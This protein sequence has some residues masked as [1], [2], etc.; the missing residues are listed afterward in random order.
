MGE[1]EY[2]LR[3]GTRE[4]FKEMNEFHSL[5]WLV[6]KYVNMHR[7]VLAI[8][9]QFSIQKVYLTFFKGEGGSEVR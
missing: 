3:R 4:R 8:F 2:L 6:Y 5:I 7:A 1:S 9:V